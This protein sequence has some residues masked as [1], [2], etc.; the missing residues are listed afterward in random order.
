MNTDEYKA[1]STGDYRKVGRADLT[2]GTLD[3]I[4]MKTTGGL[5]RWIA[6]LAP[7]MALVMGA[8]LYVASRPTRTE[9]RMMIQEE[10][11]HCDGRTEFLREQV[12]N[13]REQDR[14]TQGRLRSLENRTR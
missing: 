11:R 8:T 3:V 12:K 9:V 5:V 4:S 6:I 13:I 2:S 14:E 10:R 1:A 7:V